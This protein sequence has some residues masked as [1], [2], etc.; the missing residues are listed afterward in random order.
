MNRK[1]LDKAIDEWLDRAA[2]DYGKAE[3]RPG[4]ET[5][6]IANLNSRLAAR[7]RRLRWLTIAATTSVVLVFSVWTLLIKHQDRPT[8]N[9][10]FEKAEKPTPPP[11]RKSIVMSESEPK[12]AKTIGKAVSRK[13]V[14]LKHMRIMKAAEPTTLVRQPTDQERLLLAFARYASAGTVIEFSDK[15]EAAPITIPKLEIPAIEIPKLEIFNLSVPTLSGNKEE[16]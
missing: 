2:A 3:T 16:L 5:R 8:N 14:S 9:V 12:T 6:V 15:L 1:G 13:Q 7:K 4:F 10:V 11:D